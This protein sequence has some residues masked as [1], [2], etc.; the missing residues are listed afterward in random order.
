MIP[1]Q[2]FGGDG[3]PLHFA[4]ANGYPPLAYLPLIET[5]TPRYHV[6]SMLFRPLWPGAPMSPDD[7]NDWGPFVDD[8]F[9][10]FE[11]RG[12]A[13][14]RVIGVGHSLGAMVTLAAAL[15]RP[16]LFRAVVLL[17]PV[18]F[19][20]RFLFL[21]GLFQKLGLARQVH[22]LVGATLRRRRVFDSV[23]AMFNH[24]RRVPIFSRIDAAGLRAYV[25]ATARP[26]PDGQVELAYSPEWEVRVYET[27]YF[28]LWNELKNLRPPLLVV[29]GRE[30]DTFRPPV[31]RKLQAFVPNA[32]IHGF[33]GAGHLVPLEKPAEVGAVIQSFLEKVI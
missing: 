31:A 18:L 3:P 15:C 17:D 23:E 9:D 27:G 30:S 10:F 33:Q 11:E 26:R 1:F 22:P 21:W 7:I 12:A 16:E 29:W 19:N 20:R 28:N 2:D 24:Y 32:V 4:H 13:G 25:A 14:Q 8:L 5:L 6:Y